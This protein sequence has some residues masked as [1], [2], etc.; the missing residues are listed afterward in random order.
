M[1]KKTPSIPKLTP[2]RPYADWLRLISWWQIQTDQPAAK[3]GPALASS[4][5]GKALDAVLEL[6]DEVINSADGVK[7]IIKKLDTLF[8]KNTLLQ[9]IEDIEAFE[10]FYRAEHKSVKDYITEFDKFGNKLKIHKIEYPDDIKGYKLLKGARLQSNEEKLIRATIKD[11]TYD[12]V[13]KKLKDFFGEDKPSVSFNIK[14]ES[15]LYTRTETPSADEEEAESYDYYEEQDDA[16]DTFYTPQQ[17]RRSNF[18]SQNARPLRPQHPPQHRTTTSVQHQNSRQQGAYSSNWRN[19]K[20]SSP[21]IHPQTYPR[22]RNPLT[23]FGTQSK[24]RIC[25]SIN[26]WEQNCPDKNVNE[27]ALIIDEVI[28]HA[29]N[30]TILKSLVSE[31]WCSAVLDSGAT[32]TVCG[33]TW[34]DEFTSSLSPGDKEKISYSDSAKPFRFGDGQIVTS[35]KMATIPA[36]IGQRQYRSIPT[37]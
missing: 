34:F 24:C 27:V 28:L 17:R 25:L 32:N 1:D 35:S 5:D 10:N 13:V 14:T 21:P 20:P 6:S 15:T 3:H 2:E 22:G 8:K 30:D 26:H 16:N 9:K 4:L 12:E 29:N 36:V 19:A 11:I 23:R 18:H 31:T 7:E 33:Q 37:S